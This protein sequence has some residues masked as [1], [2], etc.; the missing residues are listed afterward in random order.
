MPLKDS[1][2]LRLA[3]SHLFPGLIIESAVLTSSSQRTVYF[4][5]FSQETDV[6]KQKNWSEWGNVVLKVSEDVHVNV[7]ARLEKEIEILNTLD[8]PSYTQ[9]H[10]WDVFAEDPETEKKF[11]YR[12]FVTIETRIVGRPLNECRAEY[13]TE[14]S[15]ANLLIKLVN[16]LTLL[17]EHPQKIIHRD[18]KP[19][20]I[21]IT[22]NGE[23]V[24]IDLGIVREEG[25]AGVTNTASFIGPCT[26]AYASP[27]QILNDKNA[28]SYKSDF[29]S[30]G[31]IAYELITGAN[32]FMIHPEEPLEYVVNRVLKENPKTLLELNKSSALFSSIISKL[33]AKH[34]YQRY[35][36]ISLLQ[37]E[38]NE[39]LE[40]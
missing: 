24:I 21:M 23:V 16:A 39:V 7:I 25:A 34:P 22:D 4:C 11:P 32:P 20:N 12:L 13:V 17:W 38:L 33:M 14:D 3:L 26:P 30:L 2:A 18:L 28:I 10:Y 9:L 1:P 27:E 37:N 15:V 6:D 5:Q 31:V 40:N 29:F 8:S 36:K 19:D 35:R